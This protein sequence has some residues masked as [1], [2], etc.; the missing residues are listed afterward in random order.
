[1][2]RRILVIEDEFILG[3]YFRDML[4]ADGYIVVG[5]VSTVA[6]ALDA[7]SHDRFDAAILDLNLRGGVFTANCPANGTAVH[8]VRDHLRLQW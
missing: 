8:T 3:V 4:Q 2:K 5:P 6:D 7:L 1:M